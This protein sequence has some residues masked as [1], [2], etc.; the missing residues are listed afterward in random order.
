MFRVRSSGN[1]RSGEFG[2]FAV[3][4]FLF[5][6]RRRHSLRPPPEMCERAVRLRHFMRVVAFFDCVPLARRGVFEFLRQ[7]VSQFQALAAVGKF[8]DPARG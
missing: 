2:F 7:R 1:L 5:H 8:H 4:F 3:A 6:Y